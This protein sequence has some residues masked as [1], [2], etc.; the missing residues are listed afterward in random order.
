MIGRFHYIVS[1][2]DLCS[3]VGALLC[4]CGPF[5]ACIFVF[6]LALAL[7]K[8]LEIK[9]RV[10]GGSIVNTYKKVKNASFLT[11]TQILSFYRLSIILNKEGLFFVIMAFVCPCEKKS[12]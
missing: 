10:G 1:G 4:C 7:R 11:M 8:A 5:L 12:V 6:C 3:R 2:K 9:K